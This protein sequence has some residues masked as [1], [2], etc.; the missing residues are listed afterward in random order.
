MKK[1]ILTLGVSLLLFTSCKVD[2]PDKTYRLNIA[3]GNNTE[4]EVDVLVFP[5]QAYIHGESLY[6]MSDIGGGYLHTYFSIESKQPSM[7]SFRHVLYTTGDT[8]IDANQLLSLVFDSIKFV[9]NDSINTQISLS[10][11]TTIN[12]SLNPYKSDSA[13]RSQLLN[14]DQPNNDCENPGETISYRFYIEPGF[15]NNKYKSKGVDGQ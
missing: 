4:F 1:I 14:S 9:I 15:I 6:S 12:Y 5:K 7:G 13:W 8:T 11:D 3:V 10:P 2:C